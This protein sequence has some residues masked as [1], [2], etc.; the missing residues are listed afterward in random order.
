M[1]LLSTAGPPRV[2]PIVDSSGGALSAGLFVEKY[3]RDRPSLG[4]AGLGGL[5]VA[6]ILGVV[7]GTLTSV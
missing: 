7:Y 2:S 6:A 4:L 5:M 1:R 3:R